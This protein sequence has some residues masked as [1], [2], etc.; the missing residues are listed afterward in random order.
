MI[1]KHITKPVKRWAK[2]K[3]KNTYI[4]FESLKEVPKEK[5]P[6]QIFFPIEEDSSSFVIPKDKSK[7]EECELGLPVPPQSLWLGYGKEIKDYLYGKIQIA[8]MIEILN[9]SDFN[10]DRGKKVLDFGCGAG[11]MLRWLY[12]FA[13]EN[14]MWGTDIS[15]EHIYWANQYLNPPFKFATTTT[16]PHLPFEDRYFDLIYAGSVFTHIDD[17]ATAWFLELRR[18]LT[19]DSRLYVTINDKHSVGMLKSNPH[20]NKIWLAEFVYSNPLFLE[21]IKKFGMFVAGRGPESQVFYDIDFFRDSVSSCF[22]VLSVNQEA[23]GFQTGVLLR[24]K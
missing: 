5:K 10:L 12:P 23:Y 15:A 6:T 14:E 2:E 13:K 3:I 4:E 22:E 1:R 16:I 19:K 8:R 21:N 11:R 20:F 24:R 7:H 18:I 17:L 9:D